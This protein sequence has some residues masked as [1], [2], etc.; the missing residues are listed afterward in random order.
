MGREVSMKG[1]GVAAGGKWTWTEWEA[2]GVD[3]MGWIGD[4]GSFGNA[5]GYG[6]KK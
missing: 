6:G 5:H 3:G 2:C 4:D 1:K